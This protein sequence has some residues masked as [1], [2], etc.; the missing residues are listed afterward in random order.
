MFSNSTSGEMF[1]GAFCSRC[2]FAYQDSSLCDEAAD[3][4]WGGEVVFLRR[5][6]LSE[7]NP[8]G[9]ECT[10]FERRPS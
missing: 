1:E 7:R 2:R 9:V 4:L 6:P 3:I 5:V 8:V 10:R